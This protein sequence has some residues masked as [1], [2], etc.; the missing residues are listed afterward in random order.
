MLARLAV[1]VKGKLGGHLTFSD[2]AVILGSALTHPE[3]LAGRLVES[4]YQSW[5]VTTGTQDRGAFV[6]Y[7]RVESLYPHLRKIAEQPTSEM[8]QTTLKYI[9]F[10]SDESLA[11]SLEILKLPVARAEAFLTDYPDSCTASNSI[12]WKRNRVDLDAS[13][14]LL[15]RCALVEL[16]RRAFNMAPEEFEPWLR[17]YS[18]LAQNLFQMQLAIR[19]L[20]VTDPSFSRMDS[21]ALETAYAPLFLLVKNALASIRRELAL[22]CYDAARLFSLY[23]PILDARDAIISDFKCA[24]QADAVLPH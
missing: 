2:Q 21:Q 14:Q 16:G 3:K 15:T 23:K 17:F 1:A 10:S 12:T 4:F 22:G 8:Q 7:W 11:N 6:E 20:H 5:I 24:A 13:V 9:L 19:T 18:E